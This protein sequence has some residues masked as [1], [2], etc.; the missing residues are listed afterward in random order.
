MYMTNRKN[1]DFNC[2]PEFEK[3]WFLTETWCDLCNAADLG[4]KDPALYIENG[5]KFVSGKCIVCKTLCISSI[6]EKEIGG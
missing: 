5:T 4:I 1:L 2:L 3:H 6:T